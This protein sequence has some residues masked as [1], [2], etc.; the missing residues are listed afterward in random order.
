MLRFRRENRLLTPSDFECVKRSGVRVKTR[1]ISVVFAKG[2]KLRLG[3]VVSKRVGTAVV[4]N[5]IKRVIRDYF[6]CNKDRLPAGD[7]VVIAS[8]LSSKASGKELRENFSGAVDKLL[9]ML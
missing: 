2:K 8:N 9:E 5:R 6:R 1:T 3:L 7:F 4:R